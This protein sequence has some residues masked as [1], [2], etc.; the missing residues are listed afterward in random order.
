MVQRGHDVFIIDWGTPEDEDRYVTFDDVCDLYVGRAL[1]AACK[2][3]GSD[4]AHLL[5]YCLGGTL[6]TIHAAVRPERVRTLT[7]LAAPV[8]FDDDGLL[9]KWTRTPSF[10]V[11]ALTRGLGNVPWQLMQSAFHMLRPTLKA[12][13][14]VHFIDQVWNDEFVDGFLAMETWGGDAVSFPGA[15]YERYVEELY[16]KN[17]LVEGTFSLSG[18]PALL[19]NIRCPTLAMTFEHDNIVP[20]KSAARVIDE[21]ASTDKHH[22]HVPGGHVGAVVSKKA[23]TALWPAISDF[24]GKRDASPSNDT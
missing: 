19:E 11:S 4:Q 22:V 23:S 15:C 20:W 24:W 1:R 17:A 14:A 3:A 2:I 5:G 9:A 13:K 18:E 21:I 12:A 8:A 6:T 7:L 16:R 10:D